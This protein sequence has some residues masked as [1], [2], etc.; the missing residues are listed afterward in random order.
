MPKIDIN[1]VIREMT[2]EEIAAAEAARQEHIP[3]QEPA[4][5]E[6]RVQTLEDSSAEMSEALELLLSGVTE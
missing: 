1:G 2:P 6:D 5:L 3:A 4:K